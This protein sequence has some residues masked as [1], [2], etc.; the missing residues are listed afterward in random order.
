MN[1]GYVRVSTAE[2][3]T[4]RQEIIMKELGVE[5]IYIDKC[6]GKDT[7]R[8]A[9]QQMIEFV[10]E[11]DAVI[12]SEISRFARST[13][14]FLELFDRLQQKGVKFMSQKEN[15]DTSTEVGRFMMTIF[16]AMGQL[17]REYILSR[18]REGI[19]A[20][21]AAGGY[22]GRKRISVNPKDFK[23]IYARWKAGELTAVAASRSLGLSPSTFYRRVREYEDRKSG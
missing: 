22:T 5:K 17:E 6:S 20:Y 15:I 18:Q 12:V 16:A 10:R 11:G 2:Q 14:D 9:L 3:N 4:D 19:A 23:A 1:I 8:P 13:R 7:K 21:K